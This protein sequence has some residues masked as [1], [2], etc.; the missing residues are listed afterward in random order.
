[1]KN[2]NRPPLFSRDIHET[3]AKFILT[4][5]LGAVVVNMLIKSFSRNFFFGILSAAVI[6]AAFVLIY[7]YPRLRGRRFPER[8]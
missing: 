6:Y 3:L 2:F 4:G 8:K 7:K 1:M 5:F